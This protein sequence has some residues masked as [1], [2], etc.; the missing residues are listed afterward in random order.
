ME[1]NESGTLTLRNYRAYALQF[2]GRFA[3]AEAEFREVLEARC[4]V[5]SPD[6]PDT[7][8]TWHNLA[9]AFAEQGKMAEA[10]T[11]WRQVFDAR[12]RILGL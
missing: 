1:S 10:E 11:E 2:L 12:Q 5:L 9:N 8:D 7:L 3:E 6:D 4:R